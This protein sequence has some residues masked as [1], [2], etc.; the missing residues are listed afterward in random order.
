LGEDTAAQSE[1]SYNTDSM[2]NSAT[3]EEPVPNLGVENLMEMD[4]ATRDK[5]I[6]IMRDFSWDEFD[7]IR[8]TLPKRPILRPANWA[9]GDENMRVPRSFPKQETVLESTRPQAS[10]KHLQSLGMTR[11]R[12]P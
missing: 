3:A 10:A 5:F 7:K 12:T 9:R 2:T 11:M 6:Q 1:S 8:K 4:Q